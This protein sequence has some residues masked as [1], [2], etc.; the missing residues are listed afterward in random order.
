MNCD[1]SVAGAVFTL[2]GGSG[3]KFDDPGW[4]AD[5]DGVCVA[6]IE[7]N[8]ECAWPLHGVCAASA[9]C[10]KLGAPVHPVTPCAEFL[11]SYL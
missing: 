4:L 9:V 7:Y 3:D 6:G 1:P 5:T 11:R 10:A 2:H 8:A